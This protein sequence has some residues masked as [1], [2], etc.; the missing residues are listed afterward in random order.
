MFTNLIGA[1]LH[2]LASLRRVFS[3]LVTALLAFVASILAVLRQV[4]TPLLTILSQLLP[5]FGGRQTVAETLPI[6]K[7]VRHAFA[8]APILH[9]IP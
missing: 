5:V 1:V 2:F 8:A 7:P 9:T 6:G 4:F 3:K